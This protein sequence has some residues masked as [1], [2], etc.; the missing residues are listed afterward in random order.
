MTIR[1]VTNAG[2]GPRI[3]HDRT[4]KA[5]TIPPGGTIPLDISDEHA[6][7][8][9]ARGGAIKISRTSGGDRVPQQPFARGRRVEVGKET[10]ETGETGDAGQE[11]QTSQP[12]VNKGKAG[13][14]FTTT[15]QAAR[16]LIDGSEDMEWEDFREAA[17]GFLGDKLPRGKAAVIAALEKLT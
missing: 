3:L 9:D 8:L 11:S 7:A 1:N 10:G 15:A 14:E 6:R 13:E 17:K 2:K 5:W 4:G 12:Q 16:A